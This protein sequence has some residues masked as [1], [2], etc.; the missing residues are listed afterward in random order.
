MK[1]VFILCS[2][3]LN[4][5]WA[6]DVEKASDYSSYKRAVGDIQYFRQIFG[7]VHQNPSRY[8]AA[9]TT[10]S[11][12]HPIKILH[13]I[14]AKGKEFVPNDNWIFA[15]V[16]AY[17]GFVMKEYLNKQKANCFQDR[18]PKFFDSFDMDLSELY[19]WGRL[20]DQYVTGKSKV[21]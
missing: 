13:L 10:I 3:L 15:K 21:R 14:D 19:Y 1:I 8:S 6:A 4:F 20:Y 7:V 16:G 12:G 18:Y 5:S 11:C 2:L 9:L 17:E